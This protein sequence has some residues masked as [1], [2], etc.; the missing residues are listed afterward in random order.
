MVMEYLEGVDLSTWLAKEGALSVARAVEFVL[1]ACEALAVAH[2]LGIVHRDLKPSNLFVIKTPDGELSVKVLDFGISKL[3]TTSGSGPEASL[4]RTAALM[5]SPLYMSP[6]QIQTPREVDARADIWSLGVILYELVSGSAP[7]GGE[8]MQWLTYKVVA[9]P[10]TPLH[11][12]LPDAPDGLEAAILRCLEKDRSKRYA[13]V[14]ELANALL[15]F[16][17]ARARDS[18]KRISG[19]MKGTAPSDTAVASSG[20]PQVHGRAESPTSSSWGRT[21]SR[22]SGSPAKGR[23]PLTTPPAGRHKVIALAAAA[24]GV[25]LVFVA[26]AVLFSTG[27]EQTPVSSARPEERPSPSQETPPTPVVGTPAIIV[28]PAPATAAAPTA[29][30]SNATAKPRTELTRK[31]NAPKDVKPTGKPPT[32]FGKASSAAAP[33]ATGVQAKKPNVYDD[34]K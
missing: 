29:L 33:P 24:A 7:F 6:E 27:T 18:V 22:P 34:R 19:I 23:R 30:A 3:V 13:S 5:G 9:E 16:A 32:T 1:H 31:P 12:R 26:G 10:P 15:P 2:T 21:A 20:A 14:S 11:D 8:T 4:T 17:P 28:A 25:V